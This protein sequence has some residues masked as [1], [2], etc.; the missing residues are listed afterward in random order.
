MQTG[1]ILVISFTSGTSIIRNSVCDL[2]LVRISRLS[3]EIEC[4]VSECWTTTCI[5]H[6]EGGCAREHLAAGIDESTTT[7]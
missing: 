4:P 5:V 2:R 6:S 3:T 1:G 7:V